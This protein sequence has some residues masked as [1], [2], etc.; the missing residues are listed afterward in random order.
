MRDAPIRSGRAA[1][2]AAALLASA[3]VV[4]CAPNTPSVA[5]SAPLA[6]DGEPSAT[7]ASTPVPS[8]PAAF[9][10]RRVPGMFPEVTALVSTGERLYWA[11]EASIWRFAPGDEDAERIYENPARGALVWDLA[12]AGDALVF[13]ERLTEPAGA[14]RVGYL[15]GDDA[16][17]RAIDTGVAE[18]G[19]PPTIAIDDS[20]I[21]WAGFA[22]SSGSPR[23]FLRV[24][25]RADT[26]AARTLLDSDV[27][28]ELLWYPELDGHTLWYA[29]IDPDFEGT[30]IGD[31]FRIETID[32]AGL[33]PKPAAFGDL[34]SVF[35]PVV[36]HDF[37]AWK[38]VEAGFSALTWGELHVLDR[39]SGDELTIATRANHPS[40]GARFVAFE[41]FFHERLL[42]YDLSTRRTIEVPDPLRGRKGTLGI[43][44]IAGSLLAFSTSV[45]GEKTV[46]WIRLPD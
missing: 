20:R 42:L 3:L 40:I 32:L 18:R 25:E 45:R 17:V 14:W 4:A 8:S 22:E 37:V 9:D 39:R 31:A 30:G 38:S 46:Y 36:T 43:P 28:E 33:S 41:E 26:D 29:A 6:T 11:S 1:F 21:A 10:V 34:E 35:E 24:T 19:A 2:G 7:L 13:S 16:D 15:A 44:S 27:D 5:P 23:T 12:A